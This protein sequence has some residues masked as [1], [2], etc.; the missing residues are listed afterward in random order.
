MRT[1]ATLLLAAAIMA[2]TFHAS[3]QEMDD[4][5]DEMDIVAVEEQVDDAPPARFFPDRGPGPRHMGPGPRHMGPGPRDWNRGPA[6]R[7]APRHPRGMG[8]R[9][10]MIGPR[11]MRELDLTQEQKTKM[12]DILTENYR[13]RL[14]ANM[15]LADARKQLFDL[16]EAEGA[17]HDAI[18]AANTAIGAAQGKIEVEQRKLRSEIQALLTPEQ[19]EKLESMQGPRGMGRRGDFKRLPG[20][21]A[22]PGPKKR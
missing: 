15:E 2:L 17:D 5:W 6:M 3:A 8:F 14:L 1:K 9:H 11:A 13:S 4:D 7:Q 18:I 21:N 16:Y 12:V 19:R 20:E 22:G 10:G